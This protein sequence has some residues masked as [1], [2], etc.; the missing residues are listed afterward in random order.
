MRTTSARRH[1]HSA[2]GDRRTP[3]CVRLAPPSVCRQ[4]PNAHA[5][6]GQRGRPAARAARAAHSARTCASTCGACG[7][8]T[9][10]HAA[11]GACATYG[12]CSARDR[13]ACAACGPTARSSAASGAHAA[14]DGCSASGAYGA[15]AARVASTEHCAEWGANKRCDGCAGDRHS[16]HWGSRH[17]TGPIGTKPQPARTCEAHPRTHAG[18]S[19]PRAR[20]AL[21]PVLRGRGTEAGQAPQETQDPTE[22]PHL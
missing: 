4:I 11:C 13:A 5:H 2:P 17:S 22:P 15:R 18:R 9:P 10:Q 7:A 19:P 21:T 3:P 1:T 8:R 6:A 14:P 20:A 12:A 16:A